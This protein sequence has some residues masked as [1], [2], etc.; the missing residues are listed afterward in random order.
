MFADIDQM[1]LELAADSV[2]ISEFG[3]SS[4]IFK[5][6]TLPTYGRRIW[7]V[8]LQILMMRLQDV[9]V[10]SELNTKHI[11]VRVST[12]QRVQCNAR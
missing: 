3:I 10:E 12:W 1:Q 9:I 4:T 2:Q 6:L 8:N 11:L 7:T 5:T